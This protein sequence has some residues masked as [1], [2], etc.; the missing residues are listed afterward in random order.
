MCHQIKSWLTKCGGKIKFSCQ[1]SRFFS[2]GSAFDLMKVRP[3][4]A[5]QSYLPNR[6]QQGGRRW[7]HLEL[8]HHIWQPGWRIG[9]LILFKDVLTSKD[10]ISSFTFAFE[11]RVWAVLVWRRFSLALIRV[12]VLMEDWIYVDI[13]LIK[14]DQ[15]YIDE[16]NN[17]TKKPPAP[18]GLGHAPQ[19]GAMRHHHLGISLHALRLK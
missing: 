3:A 14:T 2:K 16:F 4:Q 7:L 1:S 11:G 5:S 9:Q 17:G 12:A 6:P 15:R 8:L 13:A 10:R 18:E 19:S